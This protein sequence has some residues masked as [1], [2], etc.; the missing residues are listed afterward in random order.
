MLPT[1]PP[2]SCVLLFP[3]RLYLSPLFPPLIEDENQAAQKLRFGGNF[4]FSV[5]FS[6]G[7]EEQRREIKFPRLSHPVQY[8]H[9]SSFLS[10]I[11]LLFYFLPNFSFFFF[12]EHSIS[13]TNPTDYP[14]T[15]Q[16]TPI[17]CTLLYPMGSAQSLNKQRKGALA[18]HL[19]R[20]RRFEK[21]FLF[22]K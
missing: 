14:Y 19:R 9:L 17:P 8:V 18:A 15:L 5:V 4:F 11:P 22:R 20:G 7:R 10:H 16:N 3:T 13:P 2:T 21:A 12:L 1:H 6:D